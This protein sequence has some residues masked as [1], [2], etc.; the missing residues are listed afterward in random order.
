MGAGF[1]L[2]WLSENS[3]RIEKLVLVAPWLDPFQ[4]KKSD[5]FD[6]V[7][8][9]DIFDAFPTQVVYSTDDYESILATVRSIQEHLP[10]ACFHEFSDRGHFFWTCDG[11]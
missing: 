5:F 9:P 7:I 11:G 8:S 3:I 10:K 1:L 4:E 2:R 6:F